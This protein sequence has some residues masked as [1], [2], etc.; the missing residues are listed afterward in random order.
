MH[1]RINSLSIHTRIYIY[2]DCTDCKTCIQSVIGISL[3]G[4]AVLSWLQETVDTFFN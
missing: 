4:L 2:M 1:K 3:V